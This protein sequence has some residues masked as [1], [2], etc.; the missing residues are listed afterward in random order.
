MTSTEQT[1]LMQKR[2]IKDLNNNNYYHY[3]ILPGVT[4]LWCCQYSCFAFRHFSAPFV[5]PLHHDTF[6][7]QLKL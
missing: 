1:K 2:N 3:T 5:L 7:S 4:T 6:S